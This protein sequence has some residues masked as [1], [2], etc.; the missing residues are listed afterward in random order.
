M[1][2]GT[3][4]SGSFRWR[5]D[6]CLQFLLNNA[7]DAGNLV[8]T[9]GSTASLC[10]QSTSRKPTN[11]H[12]FLIC[13]CEC[14]HG[15]WRQHM[16]RATKASRLQHN[17]ADEALAV[18]MLKA[19]W[20]TMW[21]VLNEAMLALSNATIWHQHHDLTSQHKH[22]PLTSRIWTGQV[23]AVTCRRVIYCWQWLLGISTS[24]LITHAVMLKQWMQQRMVWLSTLLTLV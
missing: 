3:P 18:V 17:S 12:W 15:T 11:I 4:N 8:V 19:P 5:P 6:R 20:W 13:D 10:L 14:Y 2:P 1:F 7:G 9:L 23:G 24:C 22:T 21:I 16:L